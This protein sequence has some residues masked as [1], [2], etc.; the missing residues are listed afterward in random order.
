MKICC[1]KRLIP[2][3]MGV[4]FILSC[5]TINNDC[6]CE[7]NYECSINFSGLWTAM[8]E[9]H[10]PGF[11]SYLISIPETDYCNDVEMHNILG[12]GIIITVNL[13]TNSLV[14]PKQPWDDENDIF[15]NGFVDRDTLILSFTL[16]NY[17]SEIFDEVCEIRAI[18]E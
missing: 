14:I 15:G 8:S 5:D 13:K 10:W 9:C 17:T 4:L 1:M 11:E 2:I 16:E 18:R 3:C 6:D 7:N 12:E